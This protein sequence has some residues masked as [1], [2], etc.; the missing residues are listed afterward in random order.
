VLHS[1]WLALVLVLVSSASTVAHAGGPCLAGCDPS[2]KNNT[3]CQENPDFGAACSAYLASVAVAEPAA[4]EVLTTCLDNSTRCVPTAAG[5]CTIVL[6]C[7]QNCQR[8]KWIAFDGAQLRQDAFGS[9]TTCSGAPLNAQGQQSAANDCNRCDPATVAAVTTSTPATAA[10]SNSPSYQPIGDQCFT[11]CILRLPS[12]RRCYERCNRNCDG[13]RTA[14]LICERGCR[15]SQCLAI[16]ARCT[17]TQHSQSKVF[18]QYSQCCPDS[19]GGFRGPEDSE[20]ETTTTSTSTTSTTSVTTTTA[21]T[22][23]TRA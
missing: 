3:C 15:D 22:S 6:G 9:L 8:Q 10:A 23:T 19:P 5:R 21:T 16:K 2:Q 12:I 18:P 14:R 1:R 4:D 17:F 13:N 11:S 20:C 7:V